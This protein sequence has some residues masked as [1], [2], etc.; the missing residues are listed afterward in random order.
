[1]PSRLVTDEDLKAFVEAMQAYEDANAGL[2]RKSE[3][4]GVLDT[5]YYGRGKRAREVRS[6]EDQMTEE[7][8]E[9]MCQVD[10]PDSP[11]LRDETEDTIM[12]NADGTKV[13]VDVAELLPTPPTLQPQPTETPPQSPLPI[14]TPSPHSLRPLGT[15]PVDLPVHVVAA[16]LQPST[17][18][19]QP[20]PLQPS[21]AVIQPPP[22]KETPIPAVKPVPTAAAVLLSPLPIHPASSTAALTPPS[23]QPPVQMTVQH[24][25]Q[26][27]SRR[28]RGRPKR[29]A[30]LAVP[31]VTTTVDAVDM[32]SQ[33]ASSLSPTAPPG[34]ETPPGYDIV[35]GVAGTSSPEFVVGAVPASVTPGPAPSVPTQAKGH[36]RKTQSGTGTPRSRAKKQTAVSPGTLPEIIP[37]S[38]TSKE[39]SV[40]SDAIVPAGASNVPTVTDTVSS[41]GTPRSRA[42]KQTAVSPATLPEIIPSSATSNER[43]VASA[44]IM[45]AGASNVPTVTDAVGST[46]TPRSRSKKQTAVAPTTLPEII[47]SSATSNERSVA[48]DAIMPA[49]ASNVPTVTDA[50]GSPLSKVQTAVTMASDNSST[51]TISQD[52]QEFVSAQPGTSAPTIVTYEVNPITGLHTLVELVPVCLPVTSPIHEKHKTPVPKR[53]KV[54]RVRTNS[55][56]KPVISET[57]MPDRKDKMESTEIEKDDGVK[58]SVTHGS[59][60]PDQKAT[61]VMSALAQDLMERRNLRMG[62]KIAKSGRKQKT[63]AKP[64]SSAAQV[65][66]DAGAGLSTSVPKPQDVSGGPSSLNLEPLVVEPVPI[67]ETVKPKLGNNTSIPELQSTARETV[68]EQIEISLVNP[69]E[70]G[71]LQACM[72]TANT[73]SISSPVNQK[74]AVSVTSRQ[75]RFS[76]AK[77]KARTAPAVRRGPRKKDLARAAATVVNTSGPTTRG[78]LVGSLEVQSSSKAVETDF[79]KSKVEVDT[80]SDL[81]SNTKGKLDCAV[82]SECPSASSTLHISASSATMEGYSP[83]VQEAEQVDTQYKLKNKGV[84]CK[85]RSGVVQVEPALDKALTEDDSGMQVETNKDVEASITLTEKSTGISKEHHHQVVAPIGENVS[86]EP[87]DEDRLD[88]LATDSTTGPP[89]EILVASSQLSG[90]VFSMAVG[91]SMSIS[92]PKGAET[93]SSLTEVCSSTPKE[94]QQSVVLS[95]VEN[96]T[97]EPIS[98]DQAESGAVDATA[99]IRGDS[100]EDPL[101]KKT[102]DSNNDTLASSHTEGLMNPKNTNDMHISRGRPDPIESAH[103]NDQNTKVYSQKS[104]EPGVMTE[105]NETLVFSVT[106]TA[107][108]ESCGPEELTPEV[109]DTAC[110]VHQSEEPCVVSEIVKKFCDISGDKETR[111]MEASTSFIAESCKSEDLIPEDRC[112]IEVPSLDDETDQITISCKQK[113]EEPG[114]GTE[115][116]EIH[117]LGVTSES[118]DSVKPIPEIQDTVISSVG[119]DHCDSGESIARDQDASY[120]SQTVGQSIAGDKETV[121][122]AS[123]SGTSAPASCNLEASVHLAQDPSRGDQKFKESC[124]GSEDVEILA[125]QVNTSCVAEPSKSEDLIPVVQCEVQAPS[126]VES[127]NASVD[128]INQNTKPYSQ[129]PEEPGARTEDKE[130]IVVA[131]TSSAVSESCNPGDPIP[132]IQDT[133]FDVLQGASRNCPT[134]EQCDRTGDKE[135]IF[136]ASTSAA[137]APASCNLEEPV[138]VARDPSAHNTKSGEFTDEPVLEVDISVA[139]PCKSEDVIPE[140]QREDQV[141]SSVERG[142]ASVV[143]TDQKPYPQQSNEADVRTSD[144]DTFDFGKTSTAA[145]DSCGPE[146]IIPDIQDTACNVL[147]SEEPCVMSEDKE[148]AV[149]EVVSVEHC[150]LEN[151][152]PKDQDASND[153]QSFEPCSRTRDAE[154]VLEVSTSAT[155]ASE[156]C[157]LDKCGDEETPVVELNT[158]SVAEPCKPEELVP[159]DLCAVAVSLSVECSK[160]S[161]DDNVVKEGRQFIKE[162]SP[163]QVLADL[164]EDL[165]TTET[166]ELCAEKDAPMEDVEADGDEV[167]ERGVNSSSISVASDPIV[168]LKVTNPMDFPNVVEDISMVDVSESP[169]IVGGNARSFTTSASVDEGVSGDIGHDTPTSETPQFTNALKN[170]PD[171]ADVYEDALADDVNSPSTSVNVEKKA[172]SNERTAWRIKGCRCYDGGCCRGC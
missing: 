55:V 67:Q 118:V 97:K 148:T 124:D 61:P 37:S 156:S 30:T 99:L 81:E 42:K 89:P 119:V 111:A 20:P 21:T 22:P 71:A 39:R 108:S 65:V 31:A 25:K 139:E 34:F 170:V 149:L 168:V 152:I 58:V 16:P 63:T 142:K 169:E 78:S 96:V 109:R 160:G 155:V 115:D 102:D 75:T 95:D 127:D 106:S 79:I 84:Q 15:P 19:T 157:Y 154:T 66:E 133:T 1:M 12:G 35:K 6:Y 88:S 44:A 98:G 69:V 165:K 147:Q 9:K 27:P 123:T 64:G 5:Q 38:A 128:E 49:G 163:Q 48:S 33:N 167:L 47:P 62:P 134:F 172:C 103:D 85:S 131:I 43:S 8:F 159:E 171:C 136:E 120:H 70:S 45:P 28:G 114:V 46:S 14:A 164:S 26:Q 125:A 146:N 4:T 57:T 32:G 121:S 10:P 54:E 2:K 29:A 137:S 138:P 112:E 130:T 40:A 110:D 50:V 151:L 7:E 100:S 144:K 93:F 122:E 91:S 68:S 86:K 80:K 94:P 18:V 77:E 105:E 126:S 107:A 41:T 11:E 166:V 60:E 113:T 52:K 17:T 117:V 129:K 36:G 74:Q 59:Q 73:P 92:S 13:L 143:E 87:I 24:T 104:G 51:G 162:L 101:V 161:V 23:S 82:Q 145:S 3:Y 90:E 141:P 135:S 83:C 72:S 140:D 132:E 56:T 76:A 53:R 150:D 116:K 158:S 153:S